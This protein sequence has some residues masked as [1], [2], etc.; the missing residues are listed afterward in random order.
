MGGGNVKR[1]EGS[2]S[3]SGCYGHLA[4]RSSLVPIGQM[5]PQQASSKT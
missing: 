1:P 4:W 3:R 5:R 2:C